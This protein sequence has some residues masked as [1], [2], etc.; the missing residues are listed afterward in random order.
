MYKVGEK[1]TCF[2]LILLIILNFIVPVKGLAETIENTEKKKILNEISELKNE[3]NI[4]KNKGYIDCLALRAL[5][6][7]IDKN[8][9]NLMEITNSKVAAQQI[10]KIFSSKQDINNDE[11]KKYVDTLTNGLI[12]TGFLSKKGNEFSD[13]DLNTTAISIISLEMINANYNKKIA[14]KA[15]L[16]NIKKEFELSDDESEI[17]VDTIKNTVI[18]LKYFKDDEC[19]KYIEKFINIL[20]FSIGNGGKIDIEY[21]WLEHNADAIQALIAIGED[22]TSSKWT[23]KDGFNLLEGLNSFKCDTA[24]KKAAKLAALIDYYNFKYNNGK[25]MYYLDYKKSIPKEIKFSEDNIRI[26]LGKSYKLDFSIFD[27]DDSILLGEDVY[28]NSNDSNIIQIDEKKLLLKTLKPGKCK[29]EVSLKKYPSIKKELNIEVYEGRPFKINID[30]N[31]NELPIKIG[32]SVRILISAEDIDGDSIESKLNLQYESDNENIATVNEDGIVKCEN[33]GKVNIIC[34]IKDTDIVAKK[35]IEI[36]NNLGLNEITKEQEQLIKSEVENL[37]LYFKFN[38]R[39]GI[40]PLALSKIGVVDE[41]SFRSRLSSVYD[42]A[43]TIFTLKGSNG[44]PKNYTNGKKYKNINLLNELVSFQRKD[45][46]F[47]G[48]FIKNEYA[49]KD[50]LVYQCYSILA[51]DLYDI[52]YDKE[53]AVNACIKL[54]KDNKYTN[55][56]S[57]IENKALLATMLAG[58]N[59]NSEQ[60]LIL[61]SLIM[62]FKIKFNEKD[63]FESQN[64][65]RATSMVIQALVANNINPLGKDF[66]KDNKNLLNNLLLCKDKREIGEKGLG[67]NNGRNDYVNNQSTSAAI[68]ALADLYNKKSIFDIRNNIKIE[69]VQLPIITVKGVED[70]KTYNKNVEIDIKS[71]EGNN[72]VAKLN[73]KDFKS[74]QVS[75]SDIYNLKVEAT[76]E[77]GCKSTKEIKFIIDKNPKEKIKIRIEGRKKKLFDE[78]VVVG[79]AANNVS[80]LLKIAVNPNNVVSSDSGSGEFIEVILNEKSEDGYGWSYCLV[81]DNK[82]TLPNVLVDNFTDLKD[83]KQKFKFDEIVFYM[84]EYV[85]ANIKTKLPN[86]SYKLNNDKLIL[87][88]DECDNKEVKINGEKYKTDSKGKLEL[89]QFESDLNISIGS[90]SIEGGIEVVPMNFNIKLDK[91]YDKKI[92]VENLTDKSKIKLGELARIRIKV[93]NENDY[94]KPITFIVVLYDEKNKILDYVICK[95]DVKGNETIELENGITIPNKKKCKI[96]GLIWDNIESM[97]SLSNEINMEIE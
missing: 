42:Y 1:I 81:K 90:R 82:I 45:G 85:E 27:N 74:G 15:L 22:P 91:S 31:Q 32:D 57:E 70:N 53:N 19:N 73:G 69:N 59:R 16:Y 43:L 63:D 80:N 23:S 11:Y 55:S 60:D 47:K 54:Y 37:K 67:F 30:I 18:A 88:F 52:S 95:K 8:T 9:L 87:L 66:T 10:I 24:T 2:L 83:E 94:D 51:L 33:A 93:T 35:E 49:D 56:F 4:N 6:E 46:E 89:V 41:P 78:E 92:N 96:K 26:K 65:C 64:I 84:T 25:S 29:I 79:D 13:L 28:V 12:D 21:E 50:Q 77:A 17:S 68:A 34:R 48:Q 76:N 44:D 40:T 38:S 20:K 62:N 14:Q 58:C 3:V 61:K 7:N 71:T 75:K 97:N 72:W 86:F 5:N 36:N 39:E